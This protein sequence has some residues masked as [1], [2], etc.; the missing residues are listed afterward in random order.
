MLGVGAFEVASALV[1][2]VTEKRREFGVLLALGAPPRLVRRTLLLAGGALGGAG[3]VA[4]LGLGIAI[5]WVLT[6]LGIPHFPPDIASIYMVNTIPLRLLPGDLAAV[7]GL[8]L[9]EVLVA[10]SCLP[11]GRRD[12]SRSRCCVGSER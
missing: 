8:S 6:A 7:L 10:H 9:L 3:V 1:V 4:G 2:L 11:R 5:V 12:G